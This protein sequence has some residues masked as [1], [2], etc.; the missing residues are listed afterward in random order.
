M[1]LPLLLL[2]T[3]KSLMLDISLKGFI[4]KL[5]LIWSLHHSSRLS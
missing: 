3:L 5:F 1:I 2:L 4:F